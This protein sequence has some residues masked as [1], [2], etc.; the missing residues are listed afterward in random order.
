VFVPPI[1]L[2]A[3]REEQQEGE[4]KHCTQRRSRDGSKGDYSRASFCREGNP[5]FST[6]FRASTTPLR[7]G[8]YYKLTSTIVQSVFATSTVPI[9]SHIVAILVFQC[10]FNYICHDCLELF[11]RRYRKSCKDATVQSM[12]CPMCGKPVTLVSDVDTQAKVALWCEQHVGQV[13]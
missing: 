8:M 3:E 10:C 13:L 5:P 11:I 2:R 4:G 1:S 12:I 7:N 6:V 9:K